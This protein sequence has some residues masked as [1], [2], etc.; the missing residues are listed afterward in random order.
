MKRTTSKLKCAICGKE[1]QQQV[2]LSSNTCGTRTHLDL[3]IVG[4][5]TSLSD[6]I[7]RCPHCNYANNDIEENIGIGINELKCAKYQEILKSDINDTA[8]SF[9]LCAILC[10]KAKQKRDASAMYHHASW[11]FDDLKDTQNA[12]KYRK[13]AS[14]RLLEVAIEEDDGDTAVQCV[15]LLRRNGN[16]KKALWIIDEIG[17]TDIEEIDKILAFEKELIAKKDKTPHFVDEVL[18]E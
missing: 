17:K 4:A 12:D 14:E 9:I 1:S 6:R 7:Q 10:D 5:K 16:Y 8:K 3:R 2:I 15:D 18:S 11:V 13:K